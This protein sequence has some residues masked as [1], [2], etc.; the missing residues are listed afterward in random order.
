MTCALHQ[1]PEIKHVNESTVSSSIVDKNCTGFSTILYLGLKVVF[2]LAAFHYDLEVTIPCTSVYDI[3][4]YSRK[5]LPKEEI[6]F[7]AD[8]FELLCSN[9]RSFKVCTGVK[10]FK[11]KLSNKDFRVRGAARFWRGDNWV[12]VGSWVCTSSGPGSAPTV[13]SSNHDGKSVLNG[14]NT[15]GQ[16]GNPQLSFYRR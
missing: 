2:F 15:L 5:N 13:L 6:M 3:R 4:K 12:V 11:F 9:I 7:F 10:V 1:S 8:G 16:H 14:M